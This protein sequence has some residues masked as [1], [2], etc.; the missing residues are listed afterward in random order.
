MKVWQIWPIP[1]KSIL[2]TT[3][4]QKKRKETEVQTVSGLKGIELYHKTD[5]LRLSGTDLLDDLEKVMGYRYSYFNADVIAPDKKNVIIWADDPDNVI[6]N[7]E[8]GGGTDV[9]VVST[10]KAF[11]LSKDKRIIVDTSSVTV[12]LN[13]GAISGVVAEV[14]VMESCTLTYYT[15]QS[16]T[17][18]LSM[19]AC[20]KAVFIYYSGGWHLNSS[21]GTTN[22]VTV[23]NMQSVSSDAVAKALS[24]STEEV[25]TGSYWI[26]GKPIYRKVVD[27]GI[28]PNATN[29]TVA[30]NISNID[31]IISIS[32]WTSNNTQT[33]PLPYTN[34]SGL[35]YQIM[36]YANTTNVIVRTAIDRR[37][38]TTTYI[39]LEYT[40]TT[41]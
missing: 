18:S 20:S 32:G 41:D 39:T 10:S 29:K 8:M 38:Y 11:T 3:Q 25:F 27:F 6:T 17:D 34:P 21:Y 40:K 26:D 7:L 1:A 15:A 23:D 4:L 19:A 2:C 30:H 22:S 9:E 13:Y 35:S 5:E 33:L 12:T 28:L 31:K 24:Y 14:F 36:V 16:T 37:E